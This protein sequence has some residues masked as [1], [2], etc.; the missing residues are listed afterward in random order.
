MQSGKQT[1]RVTK[2]RDVRVHGELWH[3]SGVLLKHG[4][5]QPSGSIHQFRASLVFTAFALEAY[6]N[7][8]GQKQAQTWKRKRLSP[9]AK[10][11]AVASRLGIQVDFD[12]RPWCIVADLFGFRN[13]LA[14]GN[15]QPL[16][17]E[18]IEPV[19]E[20]LDTKLG[21]LLTTD[22]EEFCTETNA[23]R[24]REDVKAIAEGLHVAANFDQSESRDPFFMGFQTHG[25]SLH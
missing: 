8:L 19:D 3:T 12:I 23:I 9:R 10:T 17:S 16:Q 15:S 7:W 6:L 1:A 2:R 22:W 21:I 24:A 11:E 25:A 13:K 20:E 14:H 4:Q 5:Q 18:S